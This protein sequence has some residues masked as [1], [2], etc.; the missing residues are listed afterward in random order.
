MKKYFSTLILACLF[1]WQF[2]HAQ[3]PGEIILYAD[4]NFGGQSVTI[5]VGTYPNISALGFP[6]NTASSI[7]VG[8]DVV[9]VLHS[10]VDFGGGYSNGFRAYSSS[11][12]DFSNDAW[13]QGQNCGGFTPNNNVNALWVMNKNCVPGP[14]E[15]SFFDNPNFLG[16]CV[17]VPAGAYISPT[18]A[19]MPNDWAGSLKTGSNV[20]VQ[21]WTNN[22]Q[23]ANVTY[24]QGTSA[25]SL[26][27][28]TNQLSS[29]VVD[30]C[31]NDPNKITP[32]VCGCGVADTDTDSDGT[33]DCNDGCPEDPD[34]IEPGIC[35]CG[36]ADTDTDSD[37]TADCNDGCPS[38]PNKIAPGACG[39]GVADADTDSDGVADCNEVCPCGDDS[40]DNNQDGIP[41]CS[42]LL[43][44]QQ[45]A[46]SWKCANNKLNICHVD[47]YGNR[48]T[49]CVNKNALPAHLGHGDWAGPCIGC[50][51]GR[52]AP[53]GGNSHGIN[54][55]LQMELYPNPVSGLLTIDLQGLDAGADGV[56]SI[57]DQMGRVVY[58]QKVEA[59]IH[60]LQ[61]DLAQQH[62]SSGEY[63]VRVE[64]NAGVVVQK[65]SCH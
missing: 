65:L 55:G 39:C 34:K 56:L 11:D 53:I 26:A 9:A 17:T 28:G 57:L 21:I 5:T 47:E 54:D 52:S 37:G 30:G 3:G 49:L 36:V 29:L 16:G 15:V 51:E 38:D 58:E 2:M 24:G 63:L 60:R 7:K 48:N 25:A 10:C 44:Y 46:A 41:D 40:V 43:P 23:G 33:A 13:P 42:Q 22:F 35:G 19:D 14:N 4:A 61:I 6:N 64:S 50:A 18:L 27:I 45:Y 20:S 59:G 31:P 12:N 62:L 32:G 8:S 1:G